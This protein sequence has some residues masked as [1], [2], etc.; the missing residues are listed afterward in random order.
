[1]D[2]DRT[3]K[4]V[5]GS[6]RPINSFRRR[7]E[8]L[9]DLETIDKIFKIKTT[10]HHDSEEALEYYGKLVSKISPTHIF[11]HK[12][13]DRHWKKKKKIAKKENI[14]FLLDKSPKVTNSGKILR[15]LLH[16]L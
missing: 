9:S 8:L 15:I 3:I 5:K 10:S 12:I 16:E 2:N 6:K 7:A 4:L 11:T 1:L 13:C 14:V